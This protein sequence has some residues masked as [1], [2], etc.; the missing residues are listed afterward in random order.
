MSARRLL[1]PTLRHVGPESRPDNGFEKSSRAWLG[2]RNPW[3]AIS[4]CSLHCRLKSTT[5]CDR[6][7]DI[8]ELGRL[9]LAVVVGEL[10]AAS[11]DQAAAG[12][13]WTC[14]RRALRRWPNGSTTVHTARAEAEPRKYN[15][16]RRYARFFT[17]FLTNKVPKSR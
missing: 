5:T 6:C 17:L 3:R 10:K 1:Q 15:R 2:V 16:I 7:R 12:D 13:A 9:K 8:T 11:V 4:R 14:A